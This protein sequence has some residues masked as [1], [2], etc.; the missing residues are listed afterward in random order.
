MP[1]IKY[2]DGI[3]IIYRF[4]DDAENIIYIGRTN[5][6]LNRFALH[7]HLPD[8]CYNRIKYIDYAVVNSECDAI[9]YELYYIS[10]YLPEYNTKDKPN[11]QTTVNIEELT[12]LPFKEDFAPLLNMETKKIDFSKLSD[13]FIQFYNK[14]TNRI[15]RLDY[16]EYKNLLSEGLTNEQIFEPI[17][18]Y[19]SGQNVTE[20][21]F[22]YAVS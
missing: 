9:I 14:E 5:N 2:F 4:W 16:L 3:N 21:P 13:G 18:Y 22:G 1:M 7:S 15:V 17:N 11:E 19:L 20:L 10:K 6:I 8:E 12:F